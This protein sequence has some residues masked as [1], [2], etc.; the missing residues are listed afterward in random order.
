L[1]I[2]LVGK[3]QLYQQVIVIYAKVWQVEYTKLH[4]PNC[5]KLFVSH[6]PCCIYMYRLCTGN[7]N[8]L[9]ITCWFFVHRKL[10]PANCWRWLEK[11]FN[12]AR[13]DAICSTLAL[14]SFISIIPLLGHFEHGPIMSIIT[15]CLVMYMVAT[16]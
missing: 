15:V 14:I 1:V 6:M 3:L 8:T 9:H 10:F 16:A 4:K 12:L 7:S 11:R 13:L 5:K 2:E